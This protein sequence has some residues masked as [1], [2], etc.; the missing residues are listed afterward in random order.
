MKENILGPMNLV[1]LPGEHNTL[2]TEENLNLC[3]L[4]KKIYFH[5]C[6]QNLFFKCFPSYARKNKK[7]IWLIYFIYHTGVPHLCNFLQD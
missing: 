3:F 6:A 4:K 5:I 2:K 1:A 7:N